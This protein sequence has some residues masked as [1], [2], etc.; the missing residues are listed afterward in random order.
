MQSDA[1]VREKQANKNVRVR[2]LP[3]FTEPITIK[4]ANCVACDAFSEDTVPRRKHYCVKIP[5]P[6]VVEDN[7]FAKQTLPSRRLCTGI[8]VNSTKQA[9]I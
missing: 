6:L 7:Y 9:G 3:C 1:N 5:H 2:G 4:T 8:S